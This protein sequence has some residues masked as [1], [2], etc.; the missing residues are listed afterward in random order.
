MSFVD[1]YLPYFRQW[2]ITGPLLALLPFQHMFTESSH[3]D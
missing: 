1:Y 2:L 3:R